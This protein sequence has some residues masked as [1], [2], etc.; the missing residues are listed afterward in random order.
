MLFAKVVG[1]ALVF[2]GAVGA[3]GFAA[4]TVTAGKKFEEM[5]EAELDEPPSVETEWAPLLALAFEE[6]PL[7]AGT[8]LLV[9][10]VS[11]QP[12]RRPARASVNRGI[13]RFIRILLKRS[14]KGTGHS[15]REPLFFS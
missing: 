9:S 6:V 1:S 4:S 8:P 10:G 13:D 15:V 11:P 5:I 14:P 12:T 2:W 3:A 7:E